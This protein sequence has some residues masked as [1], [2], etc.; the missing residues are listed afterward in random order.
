VCIVPR[1]G[2]QAKEIGLK[3]NLRTVNRQQPEA[4]LGSEKEKL[5]SS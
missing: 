3:T 2:Q 1:T 5:V 4:N